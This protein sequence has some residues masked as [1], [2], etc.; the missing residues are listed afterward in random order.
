MYLLICITKLIEYGILFLRAT[1]IITLKIWILTQDL[2]HYT[3]N[4]TP[5]A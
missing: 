5:S 3:L 2:R 4:A 1:L